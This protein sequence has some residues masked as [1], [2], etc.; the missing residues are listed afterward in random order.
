MTL[1]LDIILARAVHF[2]A[3][4]AEDVPGAAT[5]E[6]MGW[7]QSPTPSPGHPSPEGNRQSWVSG[8]GSL[9]V[10]LRRV[11]LSLDEEDESFELSERVGEGRRESLA[12]KD[13]SIYITR[14]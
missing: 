14:N 6:V 1:A 3:Q 11:A 12:T 8:W 10:G 4:E 7:G 9:G 2:M 13:T 5:Q